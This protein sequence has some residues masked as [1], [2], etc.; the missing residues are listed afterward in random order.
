MKLYKHVLVCVIG[1]LLA[2]CAP[3]PQAVPSTPQAESTQTATPTADPTFSVEKVQVR[4]S[5]VELVSDAVAT[6]DG[7]NLWGGIKLALSV[8]RRGCSQPIPCRAAMN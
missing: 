3:A 7:G 1:V 5:P 6:G 8:L 4:Q 2:A